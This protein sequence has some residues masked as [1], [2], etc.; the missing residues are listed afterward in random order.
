MAE[1][2]FLSRH[3]ASPDPVVA[4][5]RAMTPPRRLPPP[6]RVEDRGEVLKV[7]DAKGRILAYV[8]Y[9]E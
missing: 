5:T 8:L 4:G 1:N 6:W 7:L 9:E 3:G 2:R